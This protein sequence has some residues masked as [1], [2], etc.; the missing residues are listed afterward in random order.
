MAL[1]VQ[2]GV[3]VAPTW[4]SHGTN[5]KHPNACLTTKFSHFFGTSQKTGVSYN[6]DIQQPQR[7][8]TPTPHNRRHIAWRFHLSQ[9][10]PY[11][12]TSICTP[13]KR[14]LHIHTKY[15]Q[16]IHKHHPPTCIKQQL[17]HFLLYANFVET[18][19][20]ILYI[21]L[22]Q[23][24]CKIIHYCMWNS[25]ALIILAKDVFPYPRP[26]YKIYSKKMPKTFQQIHFQNYQKTLRYS[27]LIMPYY[28]VHP[29]ILYNLPYTTLTSTKNFHLTKHA[30][31][32]RAYDTSH[33]IYIVMISINPIPNNATPPPKTDSMHAISLY[34]EN[35]TIFYPLVTPISI[36][37][38]SKL[39][40]TAHAQELYGQIKLISPIIIP[41]TIPNIY[42]T[43]HQRIP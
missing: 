32:L 19:F 13:P 5:S 23:P 22:K 29:F 36:F 7:S 38:I 27:N 24:K 34:H 16:H 18:L 10:L 4:H 14:K 2:D 40:T 39:R 25:S 3:D 6:V 9:R 31:L 41:L 21:H 42:Y 17:Q 12:F 35:N 8:S 43:I 11:I 1:F 37:P 33:I 28:S 26:T 15:I 30:K 20:H